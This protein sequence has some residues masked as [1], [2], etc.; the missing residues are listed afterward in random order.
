MLK[1]LI[2]A[3]SLMF[4]I[5]A[6]GSYQSSTDGQSIFNSEDDT[7]IDPNIPVNPTDPG[8]G[9]IV[10]LPK[11]KEIPIDYNYS[12]K[13]EEL[14]V[15]GLGK[16][17]EI[18]NFDSKTSI[19]KVSIPFPVLSIL[20][21]SGTVPNHP[22]VAFYTDM[23][24]DSLVLEIPINKYLDIT[25]SPNTLPGGRP[26]PGVTGGEPPKLG[27]PIPN[28]NLDAYAYIGSDYI[29]VFVESGLKL[30]F[31]MIGNIKNTEGNEIVGLLGWLPSEKGFR[32]GVFT[33]FRLPRELV[34]LIANS[35]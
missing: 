27:F 8:K 11:Q 14:A 19:I 17:K 13:S 20:S 3:T 18:I 25:N 29:A 9:P 10:Q 22:E 35:Q 28:T 21:V 5:S 24:T 4:M 23:N 7:A 32:S 34:V 30:P 6:C 26:L 12:A 1:S 15:F 31:K 2:T 16:Q 33:S